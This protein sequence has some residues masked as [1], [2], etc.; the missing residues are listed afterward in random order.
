M[1]KVAVEWSKG[2]ILQ[3]TITLHL[4]IWVHCCALDEPVEFRPK[5]LTDYLERSGLEAEV[6]VQEM[7]DKAS[8][9]SGK[10][11]PVDS[12]LL[13]GMAGQKVLSN[14]IKQFGLVERGVTG[15][16]T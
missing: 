9:R 4:K 12:S 15:W 14:I 13:T 8:S 1:R 7:R 11:Y 10:R 5:D 16:R 2:T 6:V 3:P